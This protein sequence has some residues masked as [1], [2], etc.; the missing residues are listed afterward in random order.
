MRKLSKV[1]SI[2]LAMVLIFTTASIGVEAQYYAYKDTE[3]SYDSIDQPLLSVEQY[4]SMAMDEVDRMLMKENIVISYEIFGLTL[5]ADLSTIDKTLDSIATILNSFGKFLDSIGGDVAAL[6]FSALCNISTSGGEYHATLKCP[7]RDAQGA[8]DLDIFK[9]VF[10]FLADNADIIAKVPRGSAANGGLDL[11]GLSA[12]IDLGDKLNVPELAKKAVAKFMNATFDAD[13]PLDD[14]VADFIALVL[15]GN[16]PKSGNST[17]RWI[18]EEAAYYFP[19]ILDKVDFMNDSVYDIVE[20]CVRVLLD[21]DRA[22]DFINRTVQRWLHQ[23]CGYAYIKTKDSQGKSVYTRDPSK[24][25]INQDYVNLVN[26]DF[27]LT[28][29]N[30]NTWGADTTFVDHLND[31]IGKIVEAAFSANAQITWNYANGNNGLFA[32]LRA[33]VEKVLEYT[34]SGL[35]ASY[36]EVLTIDQ[37]RALTDDQFVAYILRSIMNG[38]IDAVYIQSN[39]TTTLGVLF[40]TVKTLAG[41]VVPSQNYD[42][43]PVSLDNMIRMGLDMAAAGLKGISSLNLPFGLSS[44]NFAKQAMDWVIEKYGGFVSSVSG[45]GWAAAS[46]VFFNIIPA[47]WL[48]Y[49]SDGSLKDDIEAIIF[50]DIVENVLN[51]DLPAILGLLSK[52]PDGE[53]NGTIVEVVLARVTA[54]VNYVIPGSFP[55]SGDYTQLENLLDT[56]LLGEIVEGLLTGLYDRFDTLAPSLLPLLCSILDLSTPEEFGYPYVSLSDNTVLDPTL[57]NTFYMFN[58][59]SGINSA[60]TDKYGTTTR[61]ELY[62]YYIN[63]ITV[64]NDDVAVVT[65]A[66]RTPSGIWIN[67]G[68]SQVF[69]FTGDMSAADESVLTVTI[70]YDVYGE[71][72]QKMTPSA[73]TTT[74]YVYVSSREDDGSSSSSNSKRDANTDNMHVIY[75]PACVYLKSGAKVKDLAD[76]DFEIRRNP[77]GSSSSHALTSTVKPNF[78]SLDENLAGYGVSGN[79]SFEI[80]TTK[81]GGSFEYHPYV[82]S[83]SDDTV[84]DDGMYATQIRMFAGATQDSNEVWTLMH[85]V[86]VYNDYNLGSYLRSAVNADRQE[87]NYGTGN[88][89]ATY[90][91]FDSLSEIPENATQ[92]DLEA[93]QETVSVNGADAWEAYTAALQEAVALVYAPRMWNTFATDGGTYEL[94]EDAARALYNATQEIEA[95]SVSSGAAGVK[96]ALNA[97]VPDDTYVVTNEDG[98]PKLD[99]EGNE[100]RDTYEYYD[101]RHTYFGREDYVSYTYT[102]FKPERRTA[103]RLISRWQ[104]SLKGKDVEPISAVEA[105]YAT[106]RLNLYASRLIRVRAY[107]EHLNTAINTYRSIYNAGQQQYSTAS[108]TDFVTAYN[109]ATSVNAMA[110]GTTIS[111]SENLA[112]DG[113]RQSMVNEARGQLIKAAKKLVEGEDEVDFTELNAAINDN[114]ATYNAGAANW[115]TASWTAFKTAYE[116]AVAVAANTG[117][118]QAEV[119]A[120]RSALLAKAAQ[121]EEKEEEGGISFEEIDEVLPILIEESEDS[122]N[123]FLV[124]L[125]PDYLDCM[126]DFIVTTGGYTYE[127]TENES[128]DWYSTGALLTVFDANGDEVATYT[129]VLFGDVTGEGSADI[130]DAMTL[131]AIV[132]LIDVA[133]WQYCDCTDEYAESLAAD[134]CH[135]GMIDINDAML[136]IA[137][138]NFMEVINQNWTCYDDPD[139]F[140]V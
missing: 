117:A 102:R 123:K 138:V 33:A 64:D 42:N 99:N 118:T 36:V 115:T 119:D 68:R 1:L 43:L 17:I 132:N 19:G 30:T 72:N 41:E 63:S 44:D 80:S 130:D 25:D 108:W 124:G 83:S 81:D 110:I 93:L 16:Y 73:L 84:L 12:F 94:F 139:S 29:F 111:G 34:G 78:Y 116:N 3:L 56:Q 31:I 97:I 40:E 107:K 103:E 48:P 55:D 90:I 15:G 105:A 92:E 137:Q 22:M 26:L 60:W 87:A 57:A 45:E 98:T 9:A 37:V 6:D 128:M 14:Y 82:V 11:G 126:E 32:N 46:D 121:L 96:S 71:T 85:R 61:D 75:M 10:E 49:N 104:D 69:K 76:I 89:E 28:S 114:R 23:F 58:G 8:S 131:I 66:G 5:S 4:A 39:V 135:D 51:F 113:L 35:F 7:H 91:P 100:I 18:S 109:F 106:H 20:Q 65:D 13:K 77:T 134:V 70:S 140:V 38:S 54:I 79:T 88:Y 95:C 101:A 136:M 53:L 50:D 24:D 67:G 112:G 129:F 125:N 59:S 62:K 74:S 2:L 127:I 52:N 27:S 133:E 21:S 47:D 122:G 120:A 86:F